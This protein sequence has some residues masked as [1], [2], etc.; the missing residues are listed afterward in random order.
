MKKCD[1]YFG[2]H[3]EVIDIKTPYWWTSSREFFSVDIC[4]AAEVVDL[5]SKGI[6]TMAS[7]CGHGRLKPSI[8]VDT[9]KD[10]IKMKKMGYKL[11][12]G[13]EWEKHAFILKSKCR[14]KGEKHG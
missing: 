7:C 9:R 2:E 5:I 1:K 11:Y 13:F 8:I 14:R 10:A 4:I 6:R 12:P 3:K